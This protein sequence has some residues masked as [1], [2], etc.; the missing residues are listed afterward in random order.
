MQ[1]ADCEKLV[2]WMLNE[3]EYFSYFFFY[4]SIE[5]IVL[6]NKDDAY[7]IPEGFF[8][9]EGQI[10][11]RVRDQEYRECIE[12]ILKTTAHQNLT[13]YQSLLLGLAGVLPDEVEEE[14]Y[15]LRNVRLAE[16]GFLPFE[17]AVAVYSPLQ[18]DALVQ[19]DR[20]S[21]LDFLNYDDIHSLVPLLPLAQIRTHNLVLE[22]IGGIGDPLLLDRLRLEFA[23]LVNRIL[24]ADL[25]IP[26]EMENFYKASLKAARIINLAVEKASGHDQAR[27]EDILRHHNLITL[28]RAGYGLIMKLH[29]ETE[30]WFKQ[31]WF[32]GQDLKPDFWG[33]EWGGILYGLLLKRPVYYIGSKESDEYRDFERLTELSNC[34]EVICRLMVLDSLFERLAKIYKV[35]ESI[36]KSPEITYRPMLFNLWAR[37]FLKLEPSISSVSIE[38]AKLFFS[39]LREDENEYQYKDIFIK[40]FIGYVI[41]SDPE[42][43]AILKEVLSIIWMDFIEEYQKVDI[44]DLDA[45]YSR[46][47]Y[48][49]NPK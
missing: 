39:K 40:D 26:H 2:G 32:N 37:L 16:Q 15:R 10:Y 34:M 1:Q 47:L 46:F 30:R 20:A 9:L 22:V 45:R 11:I 33:E 25:L 29:W 24:I 31:S 6:E 14:I 23:G 48:I 19:K 28:F 49:G 35:D 7:N 38:Q 41:G 36:I 44:N 21:M 17:E 13:K 4:R 12:N 27:T 42:A 8:S 43:S 3:G 18:L 5:V